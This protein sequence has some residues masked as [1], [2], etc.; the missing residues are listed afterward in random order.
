MLPCCPADEL[1]QSNPLQMPAC[2]SVLVPLIAELSWGFNPFTPSYWRK[3][4]I[5]HGFM[6]CKASF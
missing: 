6:R 2:Q 3:I 1:Q 5:E 4:A